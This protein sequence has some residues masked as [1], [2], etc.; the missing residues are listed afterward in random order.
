[1]HLDAQRGRLNLQEINTT[2]MLIEDEGEIFSS[3]VSIAEIEEWALKNNKD[4]DYYI[5]ILIN[6]SHIIEINEEIA[7]VA[8]KINNWGM[9]DDIIYSCARTYDFGI[10]TGDH[11]FKD[12]EKAMVID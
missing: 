8:G 2:E 3:V 9:M 11:H 1:M 7:K 10:V 6:S 4:S 5:S 12:L